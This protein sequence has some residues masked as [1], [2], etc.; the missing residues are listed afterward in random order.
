MGAGYHGGFGNTRGKREH[1]NKELHSGKQG[2]HIVDNNNYQKGKSIFT[3]NMEDAAQLI[4]EFSGK[5]TPIGNDKERVDFKRVIGYY[6]EPGTYK[7]IPTTM[8][9]IHYSKTG[10]HIVPAQPKK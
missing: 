3:G 2:K 7:R 6:V 10:A 1:Q 8:G 4:R 9:I 5:G